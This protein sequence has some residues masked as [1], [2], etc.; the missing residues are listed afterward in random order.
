VSIP[1]LLDPRD[2]RGRDPDAY[3]SLGRQLSFPLAEPL[4]AQAGSLD[5][6]GAAKRQFKLQAKAVSF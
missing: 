6:A 5:L 4:A 2:Q 1:L 3:L